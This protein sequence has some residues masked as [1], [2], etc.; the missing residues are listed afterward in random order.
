MDALDLTELFLTKT[1]RG[2][3]TVVSSNVY[4]TI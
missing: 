1:L 2:Q 4:G 3:L